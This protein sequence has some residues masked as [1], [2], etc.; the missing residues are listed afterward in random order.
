MADVMSLRRVITNELLPI[1]DTRTPTLRGE[2]LRADTTGPTVARAGTDRM[3][4]DREGNRPRT[5]YSQIS[6]ELGLQANC[7]AHD[8]YHKT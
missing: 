8:L 4:T 1:V 5:Y 7:T 6:K 3:S 2:V